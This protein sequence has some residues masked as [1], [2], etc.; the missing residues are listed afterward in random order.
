M[1]KP[2]FIAGAVALLA[3]SYLGAAKAPTL[4]PRAA[5]ALVQPY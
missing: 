2:I 1:R 4:S 3:M 5:A